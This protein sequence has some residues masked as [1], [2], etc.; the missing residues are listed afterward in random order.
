[1]RYSPKGKGGICKASL[2]RNVIT[3]GVQ[4]TLLTVVY[5]GHPIFLYAHLQSD[6]VGKGHVVIVYIWAGVSGKYLWAT[7]TEHTLHAVT[8]QTW[9]E[10]STALMGKIVY[11]SWHRTWCCFLKQC[12]S[13]A[14]HGGCSD[15]HLW[16]WGLI[17][18]H[19]WKSRNSSWNSKTK[20]WT[21]P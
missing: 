7:P 14:G 21:S 9:N 6:Q 17:L 13:N 8:V 2:H 3:V 19:H 15:Q 18:E 4:T 10:P 12:T 16:N 20:Q 1:M 11:R 5:I